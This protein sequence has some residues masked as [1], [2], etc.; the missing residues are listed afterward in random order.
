MGSKSFSKFCRVSEDDS[1]NGKFALKFVEGL[2][3]TTDARLNVKYF[4]GEYL[5]SRSGGLFE[6]LTSI[7]TDEDRCLEFEIG[8]SVCLFILY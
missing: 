4:N 2:H 5:R 7:L 3:T 1:P 6:N 8:E